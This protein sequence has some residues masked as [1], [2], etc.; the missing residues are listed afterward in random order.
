MA[1]IKALLY[2]ICVCWIY[3]NARFYCKRHIMKRKLTRICAEQGYDISFG[4]SKETVISNGNECV[5]IKIIGAKSKH[6]RLVFFCDGEY[7]FEYKLTIP[8]RFEG[9][10]VFCFSGRKRK[11]DS[12]ADIL[13]VCPVCREI[14]KREDNGEEIMLGGGDDAFGMRLYSLSGFAEVLREA[15]L[16]K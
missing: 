2:V 7:R 6:A 11:L 3:R 1:V 10:S 4:S 14:I 9:S 13:L 16:N 5:S 12:S 15:N 8:L